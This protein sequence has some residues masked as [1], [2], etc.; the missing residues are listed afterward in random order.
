MKNGFTLIE[1]MTSV[2][3]LAGLV[4]LTSLGWSGNL[5]RFKKAQIIEKSTLL[6]EQ[7]MSELETIY[8]NENIASLPEKE[9]GEFENEPDYKWVYVTQPFQLPSGLTL[10]NLQGIP[11]NEQ[12]IF[13]ANQLKEML[14]SAVVELKLTVT[15]QKGDKTQPV[16]YPLSTYFVNHTGISGQIQSVLSQF[17]TLGSAK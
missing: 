6:L 14:S 16:K 4:A 10:L 5:K 9:E 11:Q 2:F 7:K 15:Y 17:S 13:I 8:K 1:I 12:S 3:I